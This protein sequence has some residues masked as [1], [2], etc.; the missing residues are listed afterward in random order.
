MAKRTT[1]RGGHRSAQRRLLGA[2]R[3]AEHY[4]WLLSQNDV[5]AEERLWNPL[6]LPIAHHG[7]A[8][9]GVEMAPDRAGVIIDAG[10]GDPAF[11]IVAPSLNAML[12]VT[13]DMLEAG[14][15]LRAPPDL[16]PHTLWREQRQGIIDRRV[17]WR[18]WPYDRTIDHD[19]DAWPPDWRRAVGFAAEADYPHPPAQPIRAVLAGE[20]GL[21]D[22]VTIEGHITHRVPTV[23]V[24][25]ETPGQSWSDGIGRRIQ[26]DVATGPDATARVR[27]ILSANPRLGTKPDRCRPAVDIRMGV[28]HPPESSAGNSSITHAHQSE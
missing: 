22:P 8:Q 2:A 12:D 18:A 21:P 25:I 24:H 15:P 10:F 27:E 4:T 13:A 3:A 1:A 11:V 14:I 17:E 28:Q 26:A 6:W 9:T 5:D 7:W 16:E 23:L 20:P 19:V